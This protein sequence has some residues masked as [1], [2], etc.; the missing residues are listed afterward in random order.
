M[1]HHIREGAKRAVVDRIPDRRLVAI[2]YVT[3]IGIGEGHVKVTIT[4]PHY[5]H[6]FIPSEQHY[7]QDYIDASGRH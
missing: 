6:K 1:P 3:G 5:L 4:Q 7:A 2:P